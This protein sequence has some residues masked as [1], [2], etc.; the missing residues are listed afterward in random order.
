MVTFCDTCFAQSELKVYINFE[1][2]YSTYRRTLGG[3]YNTKEEAEATEATNEAATATPPPT[4]SATTQEATPV[5]AAAA[6]PV[7]LGE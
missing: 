6:K 5:V 1:K 3:S 7:L 2:N 4:A